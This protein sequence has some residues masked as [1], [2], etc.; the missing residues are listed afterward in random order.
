MTC[1]NS[2]MSTETEPDQS[3]SSSGFDDFFDTSVP[4]MAPIGLEAEASLARYAQVAMDSPG[5]TRSLTYSVPAE[6]AELIQPGQ[7]VWAPLSKGRAQGIVTAV[8]S[9]APADFH[10][11]ARPLLDIVD[12]KP[13]LWPYQL[14]LIEWLSAYYY[15]SLY[16]AASLMLPTG[17]SRAARP[18]LSRTE[19]GRSF[20]LS[21]GLG[22][23]EL[24]LLHLLSEQEPPVT[25]DD[26]AD[27]TPG[28]LLSELKKA[29]LT[30]RGKTT[31]EKT[32]RNL[33]AQ[34]LVQRGFFLPRPG[35]RPQVK[36]FVRLAPYLLDLAPDEPAILAKLGRSAR[37]REVFEVVRR[38]LE[39]GYL[40]PA[41]EVCMLADTDL[42]TLRALA[43]KGLLEIETR[44]VR[45]DPLS[46]R[47]QRLQ[48]EEPPLLTYR[49][50]L[51][52]RGLLDGFQ[53]AGPQTYLLHG[54][55]GS[56]KTELYLRALGR[57]LKEGKQAIVLVPEIA[58]TA[59]TVDRFAARFPGRVAVRHS[60]LSPGEAYDEWRRARD[61][62]A[63]VV[64]GARSALFSPL[65][66]LGLI[67]MDEE[68]EWSYK[69]DES[70]AG[71]VLYHTRTVA[72]ELARL[73]GAKVILGSATP[74]VESFFQAEQGEYQLLSLPERVSPQSQNGEPSAEPL[75]LPSVQ[76]VDL[77]QELKSGNSSIFSRD[78][79][80]SMQR[81]VAARQQAILFLNRRGTATIVMCRDCGTVVVCDACDTPLVFHAD[82]D[83]LVCH[84]CGRRWV[85]P[86]RC[87]DPTCNSERIRHLG[88]GTKRVEDELQ[89]M[90]PSARILRWDQD[91]IAE[92]GRD[93]Y[94]VLFDKMANHE[95]DLLVGTQMIA[96]GLDLP[97]VSL[98]GVVTADTGLY[99]PDFRATERTFQL[100]TQVVGRAG[101]RRV[102]GHAIMQSY[103]PDHYVIQAASQHDYASF[104]SQEIAFR[105]EHGYPPF[106]RLIKFVYSHKDEGHSRIEAERLSKELQQTFEE[107]GIAV[108]AGIYDFIGPAPAFQHKSHGMYRYQF[109]LRIY[110]VGPD[111]PQREAGLIIRRIL[112]DMR[113]RLHG[114][115]VDVDPQSVL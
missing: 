5:L 66:R 56:G 86:R 40:M 25:E 23:N 102:P 94:Q 31:F 93:S 71:N 106:S 104:Y 78:L 8:S 61:G 33:E 68:H 51:V 22:A 90:F 24:F 52:W 84:R 27:A 14:Q 89:R 44:E 55:T 37:Q 79:Q 57:V 21:P 46:N 15:C 82:L 83:R 10:F 34:Q 69:Q 50:S 92:G 58:L 80:Y 1:Y 12:L 60:K 36:P 76:I 108:D 74:A 111:D 32:V 88:A 26:T 99:L 2:G 42:K 54:V 47:P 81:T 114:W 45:R 41:D 115:T 11:R 63:D 87:P 91:T 4:S 49:Q 73:T 110:E 75:P 9:E 35:V 30:K 48:A 95:A 112:A 20:L 103:T 28:A 101:R 16:E 105:Y 18:T 107:A 97:L 38:E 39:P 19:A 72:L 85:T 53:T 7:L 100:L 65:P 3:N 59:Q 43:A 96:K 29:Y 64:I 17:L 6:L 109:L 67:I 13:V 70:F 62:S 98:V 77:R 113:P